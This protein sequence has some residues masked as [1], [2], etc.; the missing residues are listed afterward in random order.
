VNLPAIYSRISRGGDAEAHAVASD[1]N[2]GD[3]D[4]IINDDLLTDFARQHK[5]GCPSVLNFAL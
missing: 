4:I 3:A 2:D 5:H 1:I